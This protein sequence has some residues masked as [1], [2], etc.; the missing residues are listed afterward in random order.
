MKESIKN[1]FY[2]GYEAVRSNPVELLIALICYVIN[3]LLFEKVINQG[4]SLYYYFP[5][6]MIIAYTLNKFADKKYVR[7]IYYGCLLFIIPLLWLHKPES[8]EFFLC[9][10]IGVLTG[11]YLASGWQKENAPFMDSVLQLLRSLLYAFVLS[12]ISY[13]LL[14]SVYFSIQYIFEIWKSGDSRFFHYSGYAVSMIIFPSLFIYFHYDKS[15]KIIANKLTDILLNY[16]LSPVLL[17][18]TV[19][20]YL[21][22]IKIAFVWSLPKGSVAAIVLAFSI[23]LFFLKGCVL[24]VNKCPY[25]WFYDKASFI[26]FPAY[27][28]FW[29]ATIYR[30]NQYGFT[31]ERVYLLIA[32]LVISLTAILFLTK[33]TGRYLYV[34]LLAILLFGVVTYIPGIRA[35]DIER[36][37]QS[38]RPQVEVAPPTTYFDIQLLEPVLLKGYRSLNKIYEYKTSDAMYFNNE[39]NHLDLYS[40]KGV[41]LYSFNLD[42][43]LTTQMKKA[44]LTQS[45][46][47]PKSRYSALLK[48]ELK[49]ALLIL[50]ELSL[51]HDSVY[52]ISNTTPEFYLKK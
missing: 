26:V 20:L 22:F 38:N 39:D 18:Y 1:I 24:L 45:D 25:K 50:G 48:I 29:I 51:R 36:I 40:E 16:V 3:V 37:S 41:M 15:D 49:S 34:M 13:A 35:L 32:G 28:M 6:L 5:M 52:K 42:S 44:G 19:I 11:A 7:W 46:T 31:E 27:I 23:G 33:R 2:K 17:I 43:L 9:V 8:E 14:S 4:E 47:I 12:A 21:Y 10:T 30:I